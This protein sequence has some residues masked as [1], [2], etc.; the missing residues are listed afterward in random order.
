M[1]PL[2]TNGCITVCKEQL[3]V[4][5]AVQLICLTRKYKDLLYIFSYLQLDLGIETTL[6]K[7][8]DEAEKSRHQI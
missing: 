1:E 7:F 8:I 4:C 3:F 2:C 5:H 6:I